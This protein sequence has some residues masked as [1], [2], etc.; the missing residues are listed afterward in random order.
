MF[1][2]K[3]Y[4]FKFWI[5]NSMVE[6]TH[7]FKVYNMLLSHMPCDMVKSSVPGKISCRTNVF[8]GCSHLLALYVKYWIV[9]LGLRKLIIFFINVRFTTTDIFES[10]KSIHIVDA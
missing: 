5:Y 9:L 3:Y 7:I 4:R 1:R 10:N 8:I 6:S 2:E